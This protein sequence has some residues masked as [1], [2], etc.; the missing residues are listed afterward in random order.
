MNKLEAASII[1][2]R[3]E[4]DDN[5]QWC[6]DLCKV[7]GI[8]LEYSACIGNIRMIKFLL[9]HG[10]EYWGVWDAYLVASNSGRLRECEILLQWLRNS[11]GEKRDYAEKIRKLP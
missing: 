8:N 3:S 11:R 9:R 7:W 6:C 10:P 5:A 4:D 1:S 2:K